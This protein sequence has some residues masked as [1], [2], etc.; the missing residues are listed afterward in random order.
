M[1]IKFLKDRYGYKQNQVVELE[2]SEAA[3]FIEKGY[4]EKISE[5]TESVDAI[6]SK[7]RDE[8]SA[9]AKE[10]ATQ[11]VKEI[12]KGLKSK[13][14]I[15]VGAD[16]ELEDPKAGFKHLG[17]FAAC[18]RKATSGEGLDPRL[19]RFYKAASGLTGETDPMGAG[20][21][22]EQFAAEIA[23]VA[24]AN[25]NIQQY[26]R[27][28]PLSVGRT[29]KI[30]VLADYDRTDTT[31]ANRLTS[32]AVLDTASGRGAITSSKSKYE[33]VSLTLN[34]RG[35]LAY[36]TDE[37]LADN[38]VALGV[39]L[40]QTIGEELA[41]QINEGIINGVSNFAD[42]VIG[43]AASLLVTRDTSSDIKAVDIANMRS[44]FYGNYGAAIW[45]CSHSAYAKI[46][47]LT[48][49]N[50]PLYTPM[51][52]QN[53]PVDMLYGRPLI[54]SEHAA[55]MGVEGDIILMDGSKY[56]A[57]SKGGVELA[58][59]IHLKFDSAETAFRGIVRFD[60]RPIFSST[61]KLK[62]GV[63]VSPF[64]VLDNAIS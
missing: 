54:V 35:I 1:N 52:V 63:E 56:Y 36:A 16:R 22:P 48:L 12:S 9:V 28:F 44:R 25:A 64:V 19:D 50:F 17:E 10:V 42:G 59:S 46:L 14:S 13:S 6:V 49:G 3:D 5:E 38:G 47:S 60:G 41:D 24:N 62:N 33:T 39:F 37:L 23:R 43:N 57:A 26:V 40:T 7:L 2:D 18:V 21:L 45:V 31:P 34:T 29:L 11:T 58:S 53:A 32:A 4:A 30:P 51:G 55:D 27:T 20:T 15:N 8:V 61:F